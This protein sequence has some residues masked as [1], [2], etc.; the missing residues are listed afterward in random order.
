MEVD[1]IPDFSACT[2]DNKHKSLKAT[3]AC[4]RKTQAAIVTMNST[5]SDAFLV[6]IPKAIGKTYKLI[7]MKQPNTVFLHMFIWSF[8]KYGQTTTED[9]KANRKRVVATWHPF[10]GFEPLA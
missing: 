1:D 10:D 9:H 2:S 5:L 3:H 7:H 8:T 4:N 6:S